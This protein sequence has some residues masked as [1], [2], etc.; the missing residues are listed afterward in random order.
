MKSRIA[1][2]FLLQLYI[3]VSIGFWT[4]RRIKFDFFLQSQREKVQRDISLIHP[5]TG[6]GTV[7]AHTLSE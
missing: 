5:R 3:Q 1:A 2:L 6:T 7:D 4:Q